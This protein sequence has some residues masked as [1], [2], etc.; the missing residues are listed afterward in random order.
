MRPDAGPQL[1]MQNP[2][3]PARCRAGAI[4]LVCLVLIGCTHRPDCDRSSVSQKVERLFGQTVGAGP[5]PN[6]VLVPEGIEAGKPLAEDQAVLLA[7]WNNA[8][9]HEALVEL[10]LTRADLVQAGLLPNPEF[11]YSW[12][13]PD[14]AFRYLFDLPIE[15][16]WLRPF[17]LKAAA[18]ENARACDRLTQLALDLI[19]D[20]RVAFTDLRLAQDQLKVAE[21]AVTLR[22]GIAGLVETRL[23]AG[24][25]SQL[26]LSTARVDALQAAQD[27]VRARYEV[28]AVGERLRNLTGLS[29]FN[30]PLTADSTPFD[31]HTEIPVEQLVADAVATRPDVV[32]ADQAARAAGERVRIAKLGWFRFLGIL[33]ATSGNPVHTPGPAV[34]FTV[35][36]FNHGQGLVAR[37]TAEFEMLDRRRLTLHNLV[38]Q[39]VRTAHARYRQARAELDLL[40]GKT[41]PEVEVAIRRAETAY[42]EG[43]ATY[44][45]VL[46]ANRQLITTFAREA[47]LVSDLRRAWAELERGVGR[48]LTS[49]PPPETPDR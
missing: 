33:D 10:D 17:R 28:T 43:H 24:D 8:A 22:E 38:V 40:R 49:P 11:F 45:I 13:V 47:Q 27:V 34:R 46:E 1:R 31:Q 9:F 4:S 30:F 44:L 29:G 37:A 26:E 42:K 6:R 32:A 7:L 20:T 23:K 25:A 18:A 5:Q 36:I 2:A 3:R 35:P 16:V 41:R 15:A 12:P 19:R 39:D 21:W 14:R 48:R